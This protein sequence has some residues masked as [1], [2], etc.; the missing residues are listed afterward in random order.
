MK[1]LLRLLS[2]VA[3]VAYDNTVPTSEWSAAVFRIKVTL[4]V[5]KYHK[6]GA[7]QHAV[8]RLCCRNYSE[9]EHPPV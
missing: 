9:I 6:I 1:S 7:R 5:I 4:L 2:S 3:Q 8:Y